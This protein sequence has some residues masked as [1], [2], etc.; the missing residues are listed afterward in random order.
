MTRA[1]KPPAPTREDVE[2]IATEPLHRGYFQVDRYRL[3][4]RKFDGGWT[5]EVSRELLERGHAAAVLLWDPGTD[6]VVLI[7]QFRIGAYVG[8]QDPWQIEIVAGILDADGEGPED[9]A[10]REAEE[11]AGCTVTALAPVFTILASPGAM[12]ETI[13]LYVGRVD[14]AGAGGIFGLAEEHEDIRVHVVPL[15]E[16]LAWVDGGRIAN[17]PAIITLQWLHRHRDALK[18]R[19]P[20]P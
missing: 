19:W 1:A 7:E 9:V 8:G 15:D 20:S 5:D 13:A 18:A 10:R 14:S 11:E 4:H 17:T 3:R 2:L 6:A 16:A 12:S